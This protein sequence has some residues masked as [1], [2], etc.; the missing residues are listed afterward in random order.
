[1]SAKTPD[2]FS[3]P[4]PSCGRN[5]FLPGFGMSLP[6]YCPISL[7]RYARQKNLRVRRSDSKPTC[8]PGAGRESGWQSPRP[9]SQSKYLK[10]RIWCSSHIPVQQQ[11][12][13]E[14]WACSC[15]RA[16]SGAVCRHWP[17]LA[18]SKMPPF[19]LFLNSAS[20]SSR[21]WNQRGLPG[22]L[23]GLLTSL[24]FPQSLLSFPLGSSLIYFIQGP[25]VPLLRTLYSPYCPTNE[26]QMLSRRGRGDSR[27][28]S[29]H[30][31]PSGAHTLR[32]GRP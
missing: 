23:R 16:R 8:A 10:T 6:N 29:R 32:G 26:S 4:P 19:L 25:V 12:P 24:C 17:T 14:P 20:P 28:E 5:G 1:M 3:F 15:I 22:G 31:C 13:G 27:E 9:Q 30:R 2:N 7:T 11:V 18:G 21:S